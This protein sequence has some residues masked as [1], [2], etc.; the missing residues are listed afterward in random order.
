MPSPIML[1]LKKVNNIDDFLRKQKSVQEN[2][3]R[4]LEPTIIIENNK[5]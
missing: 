2:N 1:D 4:K 3:K 5:I